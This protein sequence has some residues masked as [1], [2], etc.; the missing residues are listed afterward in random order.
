[1]TFQ[2]TPDVKGLNVFFLKKY[3]L[4][5][6]WKSVFWEI[7][8]KSLMVLFAVKL[9]FYKVSL[10]KESVFTESCSKIFRIKRIFLV[11]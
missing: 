7:L 11:F 1:M 2:W 6:S 4:V 3:F 5:V 9:Q 10:T 8:E